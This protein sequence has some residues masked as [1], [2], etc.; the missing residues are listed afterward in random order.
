MPWTG[1]MRS[2]RGLIAAMVPGLAVSALAVWYFAAG[3]RFVADAFASGR[4]AV[5]R[6]L[7]AGEGPFALSDYLAASDAL[8]WGALVLKRQRHKLV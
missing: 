4:R 5:L 2:R 1:T 3:H 6:N 8:V 7:L